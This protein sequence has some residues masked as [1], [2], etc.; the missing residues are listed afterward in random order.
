M[1]AGKIGASGIPGENDNARRMVEFCAQR[2]L[3]VANTYFKH[4]SLHKYTRGE[5]DQDRVEMKSMKDL[6]LVKRHMLRYVRAVKGM[7]QGLSDHHM[8]LCKVRLI[9]AWTKI[10]DGGFG[11][12][13]IRNEKLREYLYRE[14]YIKS[15]EGER[16]E[17]DGDNVKHMGEQV[18]Q[19][20]VESAREVEG[21]KPK[22]VWWNDEVKAVVK[23]KEAA[24][25]VVLT[26]TDEE[27]K[28]RC[29]EAYSKEEKS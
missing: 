19:A 10:R 28:E 17:G 24:W 2:K 16:I 20:M 12:Q 25:K 27:A 29:M 5:R 14:G 15:F 13:R 26:A 3:R 21:K 11:S 23:K 8:V 7:G 9:G 4:R 1:R 18:I 6:V 22:N